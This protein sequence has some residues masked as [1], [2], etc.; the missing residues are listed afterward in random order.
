MREEVIR[1]QFK[2]VS[3]PIPQSCLTALL[4]VPLRLLCLP[5]NWALVQCRRSSS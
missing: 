4:M 2:N 1:T 5:I 3:I